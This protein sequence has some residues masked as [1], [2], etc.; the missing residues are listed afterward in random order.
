MLKYQDKFVAKLVHKLN[1]FDNLIYEIQNEPW[2]DQPAIRRL[3]NLWHPQ[4]LDNW[5]TRVDVPSNASKEWQ[6]HINE[7]IVKEESKLSKKHLIAQNYSNFA[8][9]VDK[10][11]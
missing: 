11:H 7:T 3:P 9:P 4:A 1:E 10:I 8:Y 6:N 5:K 2:A